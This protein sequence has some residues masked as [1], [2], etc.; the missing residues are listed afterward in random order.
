MRRRIKAAFVHTQ[1][2]CLMV[3]GCA[4]A[5]A[6][7]KQPPLLSLSKELECAANASQAA[8]LLNSFNSIE[9]PGMPLPNEWYGS[10]QNPSLHAAS[11]DIALYALSNTSARFPE[12][13]LDVEQVILQWGYCEVLLD[14]TFYDFALIGNK[15][16]QR[17]ADPESPIDW[18]GF[19][20]LGFLGDHENRLEIDAF[21]H[22][23]APF[24][25]YEVDYSTLFRFQCLPHPQTSELY[26]DPETYFPLRV[27][28]DSYKQSPE[29]PYQWQ[30]GC[31]AHSPDEP[32]EAQQSVV[33]DVKPVENDGKPD[34]PK[35]ADGSEQKGL[36]V[37]ESE[38]IAKNDGIADWP[39]TETQEPE[40]SAAKP[41]AEKAANVEI[42]KS[43]AA[44]SGVANRAETKSD[45][46]KS[47]IKKQP[48]KGA[49]DKKATPDTL[50]S[51]Q[52]TEITSPIEAVTEVVSGDVDNF[53]TVT[54]EEIIVQTTD[55]NIDT[56]TTESIAPAVDTQSKR[57][58]VAD[59]KV[60]QPVAVQSSDTFDAADAYAQEA[61]LEQALEIG[62]E[63]VAKPAPATL[64]DKVLPVQSD[65]PL[66]QTLATAQVQEA[67]VES[68]H[69]QSVEVLQGAASVQLEAAVETENAV[70]PGSSPDTNTVSVENDLSSPTR[71][72]MSDEER[73]RLVARRLFGYRYEL[74]KKQES[75]LTM[76]TGP[77]YLY[78]VLPFRP[79]DP[80]DGIPDYISASKRHNKL[81]DGIADYI[82]IQPA[83]DDRSLTPAQSKALIASSSELGRR[84]I[85]DVEY[86][87]YGLAYR[88]PDK[89]RKPARRHG[90]SIAQIV[91][92]SADLLAS[93]PV[94]L[95]QG[96]TSPAVGFDTV[97]ELKEEAQQ[98]EEQRTKPKKKKYRGFNGF[99]T[100]GNRGLDG[101]GFS[102]TTGASYKPI[103]DSYWFARGSWNYR[104]D[105]EEF[106]YTWGIGYDDWHPG[107]FSIQLNHWGPLLPGDYLDLDN[108]IASAT[109]KFKKN[110]FME[111]HRVSSSVT[112]SQKISGD[113]VF[114]WSN[115]WSPKGKWFVRSTISQPLKGGD[116][117]WS[118][119]F[120]YA[121]YAPFTFSF[122]Y[123]NWG[124]N[125]AFE[126]NFK[127]NGILSFTYRWRY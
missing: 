29:Y 49:T 25:F 100:L 3:L 41:S 58:D 48:E 79:D 85:R 71:H 23:D 54:A 80:A 108:A 110:R 77:G 97:P 94:V 51:N 7:D 34:W 115:S 113:P 112:L 17:I 67:E 33:A 45:N 1:L 61:D 99:I 13:A 47:E 40:L 66:A 8:N 68:I 73:V 95:E 119:G 42:A 74:I 43:Q 116:T 20:A 117:S 56:E 82:D 111:K 31:A 89:F 9:L 12:L 86:Y 39:K 122:E 36:E 93:A 84:W 32:N 38:E 46:A 87:N 92:Q 101:D 64:D 2:L 26:L 5:Y 37:L 6:D 21:K 57:A 18:K 75:M 126:Y 65:T 103:K 62:V 30:V 123:N 50:A 72:Q 59:T 121:N 88:R 11:L 106:R 81:V 15:I 4:Q 125:K 44:E 55:T 127:D 14:N 109:Y 27:V 78:Y 118:Y 22:D 70:E 52:N 96:D 105:D 98:N 124:Y 69:T 83:G 10:T 91:A 28:H 107:T 63:I 102:I 114:S 19:H 35:N 53:S 120:G 60:K 76:V 90:N 24:I 16:E 104:F